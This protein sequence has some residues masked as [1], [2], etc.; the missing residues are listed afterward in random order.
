MS[1]RIKNIPGSKLL[2]K[3]SELEKISVELIRNITKRNNRYCMRIW[4]IVVGG[5]LE[6][7]N[8][9]L[10]AYQIFKFRKCFI[11]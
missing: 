6:L 1:K 9:R 8:I 3:S 2:L 10:N 5:D 7:L 4:E 11:K